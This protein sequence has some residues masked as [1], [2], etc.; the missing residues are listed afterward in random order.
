M[1]EIIIS[2]FKRKSRISLS[3]MK[4]QNKNVYTFHAVAHFSLAS[5]MNTVSVM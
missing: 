4:K 1:G 5:G 3:G 2:I